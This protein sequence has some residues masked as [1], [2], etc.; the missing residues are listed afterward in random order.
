MK[1]IVT[2]L[3]SLV[4]PAALWA[5]DFDAAYSKTEYASQYGSK[6]YQGAVQPVWL[7]DDTFVYRTTEPGGDAWYR[8]AGGVRTPIDRE[9]FESATRTPRRGGAG[10]RDRPT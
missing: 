9:A 6:I 4:L 1:Q 8:V 10:G 7:D 3:L 2:F 5:Q